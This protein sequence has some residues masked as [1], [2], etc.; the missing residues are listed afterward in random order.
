MK[1][2]VFHGIRD[3]QHTPVASAVEAYEQFDRREQGLL[4][5]ELEPAA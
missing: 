5:L 1:A 4:K 2:V 3:V